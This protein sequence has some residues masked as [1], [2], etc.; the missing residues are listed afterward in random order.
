MNAHRRERTPG[1]RHRHAVVSP[2]LVVGLAYLVLSP[3]PA[4]GT[5]WYCDPSRGMTATQA[6]TQADPWGMLQAVV[7]AR[8][9]KPS[10][11]IQDGDTVK[12]LSG[13]HA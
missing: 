11:K 9:F 6:G 10:V 5:T 4:R 1:G 8:K 12:L 3:S 2:I 13:Y 7:E